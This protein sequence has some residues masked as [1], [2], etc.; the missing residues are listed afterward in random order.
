MTEPQKK[1][2]AFAALSLRARFA[3]ERRVDAAAES[4][5]Q[6]LTGTRRALG[7]L[8]HRCGDLEEAKALLAEAEGAVSSV[9]IPEQKAKL[10]ARLAVVRKAISEAEEV[11]RVVRRR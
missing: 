2:G 8:G 9:T 6:A 7:K 1:I 3:R 11:C 5:R 4:A 10:E